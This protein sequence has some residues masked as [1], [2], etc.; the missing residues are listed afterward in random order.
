[1]ACSTCKK[2]INKDVLDGETIEQK[3]DVS[4]F[5]LVKIVV[6]L[7]LVILTPILIIL[8]WIILFKSLFLNKS[9]NI[10]NISKIFTKKED[11][12]KELLLD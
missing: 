8:M 4:N 12:K 1:M 6:F 9:F 7:M 10:D 2:K 3:Q 5:I 11:N